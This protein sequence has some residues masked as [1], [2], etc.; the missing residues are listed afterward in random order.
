MTVINVKSEKDVTSY[1]S[2]VK[3]ADDVD[4]L[5]RCTTFMNSKQMECLV[6]QIRNGQ[7][8]GQVSLLYASVWRNEN[9]CSMI[10]NNLQV[11]FIHSCLGTE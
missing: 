6:L 4:M 10:V 9:E 8:V 2:I 11:V 7:S 5:H 3:I 1:P